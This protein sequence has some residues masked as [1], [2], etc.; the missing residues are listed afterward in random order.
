MADISAQYSSLTADATHF[1]CVQIAPVGYQHPTWRNVFM[2]LPVVFTV[3]AAI[4]SLLVS[5]STFNEGEHDIF[6][7]GSN[8]AL[9]PGVLRLKTPGFFD[10]VL[11]AQ[12]VVISGQFNIDYP[13]FYSLFISNF[14]WSFL[15]FPSGWLQPVISQMFPTIA[16]NDHISYP[17]WS[18]YKRQEIDNQN[19]T[20]LNSTQV[21]V[22]GTAMGDFALA[23]GVDI[24]AL[25][26]T[27]MVY[28]L[29]IAISCVT[30]CL[31]VWSIFYFSEISADNK[32]I[33][34]RS[35]KMKDFTIGKRL[36]LM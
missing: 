6:L 35:K 19:M 15:L 24:N 33:G 9:L 30:F 29:I 18:L 32:K 17:G 23:V 20:S 31:I 2:Y 21:N 11:Y 27:F 14:S 3:S 8:Y 28:M 22:E 25:F 7:L 16:D 10:L 1:L 4:I 36:D 34:R 26:F 5:F 12:F 13:R